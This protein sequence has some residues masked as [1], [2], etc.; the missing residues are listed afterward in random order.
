MTF[1][2]LLVGFLLVLEDNLPEIVE[3]L[4][5]LIL[6]ETK[7]KSMAQYGPI[8]VKQ[9]FSSEIIEK[10]WKIFIRV[11]SDINAALGGT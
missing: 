8:E 4:R 9:R 6:D 5:N 1:G 7:R 10:N 2:T 3:C 11:F